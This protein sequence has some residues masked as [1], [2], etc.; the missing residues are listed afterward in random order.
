MFSQVEIKLD[1]DFPGFVVN[2]RWRCGDGRIGGASRGEA[3]KRATEKRMENG[4]REYYN[5]EY[6]K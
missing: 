4:M 6:N 2:T 3:G 5:D 1:S